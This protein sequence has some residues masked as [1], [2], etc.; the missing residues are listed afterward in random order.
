MCQATGKV[1]SLACTLGDM[2]PGTQF[3]DPNGETWMVTNLQYSELRLPNEPTSVMVVNVGNGDRN[4][5][6]NALTNNEFRGLVTPMYSDLKLGYDHRGR[7]YVSTALNEWQTD[8]PVD[9]AQETYFPVADPVEV[10]ADDAKNQ[11]DKQWPLQAAQDAA[12][13]AEAPW[14]QPTDA[15]GPD[16]TIEFDDIRPD[17]DGK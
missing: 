6:G 15:D 5:F 9:P 7:L 3:H 2:Q 16:M 13:D 8:L 10:D 12:A 4:R 11:A 14:V 17:S 1:P